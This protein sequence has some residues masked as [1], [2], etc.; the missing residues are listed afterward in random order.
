MRRDMS[1]VVTE[2]P[3]RGHENPSRKWGRRLGKHEYDLD[4]HGPSRA[5]IAR[6]HQYGWEAKEFSDVIGPLRRYLRK[7]VGRPWNKVWSEI[8]STLDSRSLT[9]RH[10]FTHVWQEVARD[11][12]IGADGRIY[13]VQ[14]WAGER[15][16]DGLFVHPNTGLLAFTRQ[17]GWRYKGGP[18]VKAREAVRTFGLP[19]E[20]AADIRRYRIDGERVWEHRDEGWFIHT[21]RWVPEALIETIIRSDGRGIRR[22]KPAHFARV[23]TKQA[24]RKEIRAAATL[25]E[26]DPLVT[27]RR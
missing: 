2:A 4:D 14:P 24:S 13:E 7:Q 21:Y 20:T 12:S 15:L 11:V 1:K 25:L 16:V 3:R 9:G 6:H 18:F 19:S 5:P 10:I 26:A 23:S 17:R 22:Y 8:T 27:H